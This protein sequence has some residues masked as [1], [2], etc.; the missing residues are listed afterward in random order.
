VQAAPSPDAVYAGLSARLGRFLIA[1]GQRVS[2]GA[3]IAALDDGHSAAIAV[4][5]EG[6]DVSTALLELRQKLST[7]PSKGPPPTPIELLA[8][9]LAVRLARERSRLVAHPAPADVAAARLELSKARA[10]LATVTRSPGPAALASTR[11]A[12]DVA[13]QRLTQAL[14]PASP[15]DIAAAKL[16]LAKA[17]AD[18]DA[19]LTTPAPPGAAAVQ[20][21]QLAVTL[22]QQHLAELPPGSPQSDVTAAQLELKRAEADLETLQRPALAPAASALTA[23]QSAL[24]LANQKLAQLASPPSQLTVASAR[25]DL[26]KAQADLENLRRSI[27][28][29]VLA[30]GRATVRVARLHLSQLLH[31]ATA[32]RDAARADVAKAAADLQTLQ[33]RGAPAGPFDIGVARLKLQAARSRLAAARLQTGRLT[34]RAPF[35]GTVTALLVAPGTPTDPS[36]AV[37]TVA[38]LAHLAVDV[39][40][41]EFDIAKVALGN[42]A[43]LA[44]DALGG[45][46]LP[47]RVAYVAPAGVDSGGVV[48]FPV[49]V[50]L[51]AAARVKP[52]MNVSVKIVVA[53]RRNVVRIPLEAVSGS[54]VTVVAADGTEAQRHVSLGLADNK[55]VEIK[56]GVQP[57]ESVLLPTSGG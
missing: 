8:D 36:T 14:G 4:A 15:V 12:I 11:L 55:N 2:A 42:R 49:R 6:N 50:A 37:A 46:R 57:G 44:V 10:D 41:S 43:T 45:R 48:T 19:L 52:G 25:L 32:T 26:L 35:A 21:A 28:P 33:H 34:V 30:A 5:Q 1:P 53:R 20:A 39:N 24:D 18:L 27:A 9:R 17:Q 16:E 54:I 29:Q 47:G 38:D 13:V 31:P 56:S 40:L 23:A 22:A 3:P 7:D 51:T